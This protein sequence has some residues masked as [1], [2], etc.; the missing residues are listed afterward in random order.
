MP[1]SLKPDRLVSGDTIG[2]IGPASAPKDPQ[3]MRAAAAY[4]ESLGY[5][6][7]NKRDVYPTYGYLCGTDEQRLDE[8]NYFLNL[9]DIKMIISARGGYGTLRLLSDVD[10][11]AARRYPKL[12]VGYS[13]ITALQLALFHRS[14]LP[15]ISGPMLAVEWADLDE[16]SERLFWDIAGG[17]TPQPLLGPE[18]EALQPVRAGEVEG[19][20]LGG[21]LTL[22]T[23]LIGTPFLPPLEGT[24]LFIEEVGEPPYRIDGLLAQ[25]KLA[26][27]LDR[28][29]GLIFGA[30]TDWEDSITGPTLT[31]KQVFDDY[32]SSLKCPV[33][34][35][36]RYGHFPVKN[37]M[38]IGVKARLTVSSDTASLSILEPVAV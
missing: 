15:S 3:K 23:R 5:R 11:E 8:L 24:L 32:V 19:I 12:L 29:G 36:L 10:F 26:G 6:V 13:D 38:P 4:L 18:G 35:G 20:L 2:I 33:A 14:G 25:L 7:E 31:M 16:N 22:I 9:A 37:T 21:N 30:F 34:T 28:L 27:I 17:G 1:K